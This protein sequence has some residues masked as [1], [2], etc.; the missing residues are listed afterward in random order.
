MQITEQLFQSFS[1]CPYKAYLLLMG[2][3]GEKADY[4][5][6]QDELDNAYI[7][8]LIRSY[9][10]HPIQQF[11]VP[12][13]RELNLGRQLIANVNVAHGEL[14]SSSKL[15]V[16]CKGNSSL[17]EFYYMPIV[18]SHKNKIS[19]E[20]KIL[21]AFRG[22]IIERMQQKSPEYGLIIYGKPRKITKVKIAKFVA[23]VRRKI[24]MVKTCTE[25]PPQ[26]FI[27][28]HCQ[29]CEF[30]ETCR[31][32]AIK[33]ENLSLLGQI[34]AKEALK[35]NK[36]GIFTLTQLSYTFRPRRRR[37]SPDNYRG[38][39]SVAL[40]A[41]AIRDKKVYVQG[42]PT[43]PHNLTEIYFDVEGTEDGS[44]FVYLL[45]LLICV[46]GKIEEH[47]FWADSHQR[48]VD[49][50]LKF[51]EVIS[52]Y[53]DY[54]LY[55]YGS[56]E[57]SYLK[58]MK[59]KVDVAPQVIDKIIEKSFNLLSVFFHNVYMPTYT[60]GLKDIA[61]YLGFQW[62]DK[63]ASG[64]QSI[65]WRK[66]WEMTGLEQYK[67]KLIRYNMED[68]HALLKMKS[69]VSAVLARE[70]DSKEN[71]DEG[72]I[73]VDYLK[74]KSC[75]KFLVGE[76]AFPEFDAL[77]KCAHFD[78]QRERVHV[79]T[80]SYL[81][82][83]YAKKLPPKKRGQYKYAGAPNASLPPPNLERCPYCNGIS[84]RSRKGLSKAVIDIKFSKSGV[85]R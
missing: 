85:K 18:A 43:I 9:C 82:K 29:I 28:Q 75:F 1:H 51:Y 34:R 21:L 67:S 32:Q 27:N 10:C 31:E 54:V 49:L 52:R 26:L 23:E 45:G 8:D 2:M 24:E 44:G 46:D 50:F 14:A 59:R 12:N 71:N 56:Y 19:K 84:R 40:S 17:G 61:R 62:S 57:L 81:K 65:V 79:R 73:F 3:V 55:H 76:F 47:S 13:A 63:K 74:K 72:A 37:K 25:E 58:R 22:L 60:N 30:N 68:C 33:D 16:K 42:V 11:S 41:M 20:E 7:F 4:E 38:P 35:K 80:N 48:E 6:L 77:N 70:V 15:I 5:L 66:R 39:H 78:Y 69:F 64:I 53:D 36:K 83:Y